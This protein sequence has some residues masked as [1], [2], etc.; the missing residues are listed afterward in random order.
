VPALISGHIRPIVA[1]D[2]AGL[3]EFHD[4]LSDSSRYFRFFS[5]HPTLREQDARHFASVDGV[6]RMAF[7]AEDDGGIIGV[8]RYDRDQLD[9]ES[10]EVAFAVGDE[11]QGHGIGTTLLRRLAAHARTQGI[12]RFKAW[13]LP[14]NHRM[15]DMFRDVVDR[16]ECEFQSG[17]ILVQFD[18][19]ALTAG[20]DG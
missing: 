18:L 6:D 16:M 8:G 10:A 19:A 3:I 17:V 4:K 13:V 12:T 1:E 7:V 14:T 20:D 15:L 11:H 5:V 9:P 2:A